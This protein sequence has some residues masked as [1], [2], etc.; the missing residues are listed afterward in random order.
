M[1]TCAGP[2]TTRCPI[3]RGEP[4]SLRESVDVAVVYVDPDGFCGGTNM[5]PRLACAADSSS[6]GV[7]ALEGR[8]DGPEF[9]SGTAAI[10]A[11]SGPAAILATLKRLLLGSN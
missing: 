3:M 7:I 4:C 6:P 1:K 11:L 9:A 8:L 10:G 5:I 2:G